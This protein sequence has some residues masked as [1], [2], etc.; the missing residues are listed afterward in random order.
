ME[1][2]SANPEDALESRIP[3]CGRTSLRALETPDFTPVF[4]TDADRPSSKETIV[5][6]SFNSS[7]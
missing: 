4:T 3:I 1:R 5:L 7:V 2:T 6:A